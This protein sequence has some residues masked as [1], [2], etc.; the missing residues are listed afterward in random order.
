MVAGN[1]EPFIKISE[2]NAKNG[3]LTAKIK[4][5]EGRKISSVKTYYITEKEHPF[6]DGT[7]DVGWKSVSG[8]SLTDSGISVALPAE[9]TY[10]Y[11]TVTDN[12]GNMIS[13]RYVKVE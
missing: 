3:A 8:Y 2:V 9:A 1:E 12:E 7:A 11:A 6:N 10:C 13:T 5:P 4:Y